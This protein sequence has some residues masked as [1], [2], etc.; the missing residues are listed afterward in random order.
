MQQR[1]RWAPFEQQRNTPGSCCFVCGR[2][3]EVLWGDSGHLYLG[4]FLLCFVV[5]DQ[6]QQSESGWVSVVL[7]LQPD[8]SSR[9]DFPACWWREERCGPP[10]RGQFSRVSQSCCH[11][12]G[13]ISLFYHSPT[14]LQL[15]LWCFT[16]SVPKNHLWLQTQWLHFWQAKGFLY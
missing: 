2:Q 6:F 12:G 14:N 4:F 8:G 7:M 16:C 13:F 1:Q 11:S 15:V 10:K 5:E 9:W 3:A